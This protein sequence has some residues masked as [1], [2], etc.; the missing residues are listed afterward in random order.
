M[1][2]STSWGHYVNARRFKPALR[3]TIA[4]VAMIGLFL[5]TVILPS[6]VYMA[7]HTLPFIQPWKTLFD[8]LW[9]L[10]GCSSVMVAM[11]VFISR[12]EERLVRM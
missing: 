5:V 11:L 10:I 3:S 7:I 2:C 6:V 1:E 9:L 8:F 4:A 12:L